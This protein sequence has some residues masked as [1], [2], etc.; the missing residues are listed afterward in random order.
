MV[1][2][3]LM[4]FSLEVVAIFEFGKFELGGFLVI[5]D[6]KVG[7]GS[8]IGIG[9]IGIF[10]HEIGFFFGE[11]VVGGFGCFEGVFFVVLFG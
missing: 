7:L 2:C 3:T 1:I 6:G 9:L 5:E 8:F 10:H 4:L 11:E